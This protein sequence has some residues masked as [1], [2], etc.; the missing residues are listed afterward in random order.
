MALEP[1]ARAL[2]LPVE[3]DRRS[4]TACFARL[5]VWPCRYGQDPLAKPL[6]DLSAARKPE[7]DAPRSPL[8]CPLPRPAPKL[9]TGHKSG[10]VIQ[11][12]SFYS[13]IQDSA[14][15]RF[16][17]S[18]ACVVYY[19]GFGDSGEESGETTRA[20]MKDSGNKMRDLGRYYEVLGEI[21]DVA[22]M[23]MKTGNSQI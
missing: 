11:I 5:A 19:E 16:V 12:N 10:K 22:A 18:K 3:R 8:R 20:T 6:C 4:D 9:S 7:R 14:P 13:K 21:A 2:T 15:D 23:D 1:N 17:K